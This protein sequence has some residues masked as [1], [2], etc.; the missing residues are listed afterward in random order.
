[1]DA[2]FARRSIRKFTDESLTDS[3]IQQLLRAGMAA[4]C[5][6]NSQNRL[7]FVSEGRGSLPT[8]IQVHPN[9]FA[10]KTAAAAITVCADLRQAA[11]IDPLNPWWVQ[12]CA[13]AMENILVE[14]ADMGLGGLWIGVH[15][16]P[17]RVVAVQ[18]DLGAPDFIVPLGVAALGH[19]D[20]V[21]EP[22]DRFEGDKVF[23]GAYHED[24]NS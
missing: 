10:L 12:D 22:I 6:K 4:A 20:K 18:K 17:K 15:P 3:Q 24:N 16:D 14:A 19:P 13:A 5:A 2:I 1:M 8:L 7:F 9:A 11:Q 21:R 23:Y